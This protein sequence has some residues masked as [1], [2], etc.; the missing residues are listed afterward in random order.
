[1]VL[2]RNGDCCGRN[3]ASKC[4]YE[5][6]SIVHL[7]PHSPTSTPD[8][9]IHAS[10]YL[11]PPTPMCTPSSPSY[12]LAMSS[13]NLPVYIIKSNSSPPVANSMTR[14]TDSREG[15]PLRRGY[16]T[17]INT[18]RSPITCYIEIWPHIKE[19]RET[20][21][22]DGRDGGREDERMERMEGWQFK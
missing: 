9:P 4:K 16:W 15:L 18:S 22:T 7:S 3:R 17:F 21:R 14:I 19:G 1:M 5:R 13:G 8:H 12:V 6:S 10:I 2:V 11:P 20:G